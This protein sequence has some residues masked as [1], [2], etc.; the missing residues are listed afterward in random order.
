VHLKPSVTEREGWIV[1]PSNWLGDVVLAEVCP[2]GVDVARYL[3]YHEDPGGLSLAL[4]RDAIAG[5]PAGR[6]AAVGCLGQADWVSDA[7]AALEGASDK[8]VPATG[9]LG[10]FLRPSSPRAGRAGELGAELADRLPVNLHD[11]FAS[12]AAFAEGDDPARWARRV[13]SLFDLIKN[14]SRGAGGAR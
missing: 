7:V 13:S 5:R 10:R 6:G 8:P 2:P 11:Q 9:K 12:A 3:N 4:G 1:D 14:P